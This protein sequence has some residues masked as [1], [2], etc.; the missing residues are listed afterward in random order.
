MNTKRMVIS[1]IMIVLVGSLT[2][3]NISWWQAKGEWQSE[4]TALAGQLRDSRV[5]LEA[6]QTEFDNFRLE[7]EAQLQEANSQLADAK[8]QLDN[9]VDHVF[10]LAGEIESLRAELKNR[11]TYYLA[12]V[13]KAGE[14][15]YWKGYRK[16]FEDK[17]VLENPTYADLMAFLKSTVLFRLPTDCC[18]D[19][20]AHLNNTAEEMGIRAGYVFLVESYVDDGKWGHFINCFETVDKGIVYVEPKR[21]EDVTAEVAVGKPYKYDSG[22]VVKEIIIIW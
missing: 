12:E 5:A 13:K 2:A 18:V 14:L 19:F 15:G 3:T 16:A 1:L 17:V 21:M 4:R 9:A 11:K 7:K 20:A 10:L 22:R 8:D 6:V